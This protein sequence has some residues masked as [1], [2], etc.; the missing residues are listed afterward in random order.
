MSIAKIS[1]GKDWAKQS[2][3]RAATKPRRQ[4]LDLEVVRSEDL[5]EMMRPTQVAQLLKRHPKTIEGLRRE[6]KIRFIKLG[7]RYYT[8]PEWVAEYLENESVI[9]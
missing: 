9:I 6:R 2:A 8:T 4:K 7:G 3:S 5:P 1:Y